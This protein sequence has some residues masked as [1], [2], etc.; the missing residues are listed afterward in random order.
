[1]SVSD[2]IREFGLWLSVGLIGIAVVLAVVIAGV[3]CLCSEGE[4]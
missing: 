1:M 2:A 3:I 4:G